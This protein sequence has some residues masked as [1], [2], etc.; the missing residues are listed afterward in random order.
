MAII[1]SYQENEELRNSDMLVGTASTLHNGQVRKVTKN[2]SLGQLKQF[3]NGGQLTLTTIGTSGPATLDGTVLNVPV[4]KSDQTYV[5]VQ[6]VPA[7]TWTITH[8]LNKYPSVSVVNINN[9]VMYGD[10]TYLNTNQLQIEFSAGFS[11]KAYMN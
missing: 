4:Y 6:S 11:G 7:T 10:V 1:Y 8:N 2:F 9:V 3:I 5:F